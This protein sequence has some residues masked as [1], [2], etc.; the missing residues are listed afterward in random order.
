[1]VNTADAKYILGEIRNIPYYERRMAEL[2]AKLVKID[3]LIQTATDP[4]SPNGGRD[5]VIK[6]KSVRVK[7]PGSGGY[8]SGAAI[9]ALITKQAPIE[10]EYA[11][12]HRRCM[13]ARNYREQVL[14]GDETGFVGAFLDG[15]KTYRDLQ[16]EF[17]ISNPY[18]KMLR[19]IAQ[20]VEKV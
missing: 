2:R 19:I 7:V 17:Y 18:D 1:M 20:Y 14:K 4:G 11:L 3:L 13:C 12:F 8:D 5:V 6:G 10:A 16:K 9:S 15:S